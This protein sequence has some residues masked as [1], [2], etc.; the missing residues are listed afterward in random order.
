M[1]EVLSK[2]FKKNRAE[3]FPDDLWNTFVL[4][5]EYEQC[6]LLT[7]DKGVHVIGGRGTGKTMFLKYHCYPTQL[8]SSREIIE[9]G[10]IEQ[11]GI[12]WRPDT[13][14]L[15]LLNKHYLGDK[16]L[17]I[18]NTY[19]GLSLIMKFSKF[20]IK[21]IN[22]N[23]YD[24]KTISILESFVIS[25]ILKE[26]LHCHE[27]ILY[28]DLYKY[29]NGLLYKIQNWLNNPIAEMP[30][31]IDGKAS[32]LYMISE[33]KES[34]LLVDTTFHIFIDEFENLTDS[35]QI[36][37]N[38]WM[39]H[40]E[41]PLLFSV[42]YKKYANIS[43]KTSGNETIQRRNDH[44]VIDILDDVYAKTNSSFKILASEIIASKLQVFLDKKDII[45]LSDRKQLVPRR[46]KEYKKE[47]VQIANIVFP[48][49][50]YSEIAI[51]ILKDTSLY[52]KV[53]KN[54]TQALKDKNSDISAEKFIDKDFASASLVNSILLFRVKTKPDDLLNTF[55]KYK[56]N[57]RAKSVPIYKELIGNNLVGAI[58]YLYTA[59]PRRTCPIYSGFNRFCVM[60]KS[61]LRHLLELCYQ[62]FIELEDTIEDFGDFHDILP[63]V[64][65]DLQLK[66][67][68]FCSK[69][70]L[71]IISE[72]GPY[73][74][75]LQKIANR[76]GRIFNLKQR[77]KTQ[78]KPENIH[79][80][81]E[82]LVLDSVDDKIKTLI[83]QALLWNVLQEHDATKGTA[84]NIATKEYM[85]TPMLAPFYKIT[86]RKIHKIDFTVSELRTVFLENDKKF[87]IFYSKLIKDWKVGDTSQT[88]LFGDLF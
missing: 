34:N 31:V 26:E 86:T 36:I 19:V 75:D 37:I 48:E 52:H 69:Q 68:K 54:I 16:W 41:K 6:N 35:Q 20:I 1:A 51:D 21:F 43:I 58:L 45:P 83:N 40:G 3:E 12:Y 55:E 74:Q 44:R 17:A 46:I 7:N 60:S 14:F 39:K 80:S 57:S 8:S 27:T 79:F 59:F 66:A 11:I 42:A 67:A 61:N 77:I 29:C 72:L 53:I 88:S 10:D 76:L 78:S 87:D 32:L 56:T 85:L 22:S 15:Q 47:M 71:E 64:P 13:H 18:F 63:I 2:I 4:P 65:I 5:T 23:Y 38:D 24:K 70:E 28:T 9:Q 50:E 81:V 62:S 25:D 82:T 84:D 73:G 30:L 33:L 49:K